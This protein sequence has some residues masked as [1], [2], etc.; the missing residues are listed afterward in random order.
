MEWRPP[1][2]PEP[3]KPKTPELGASLS[4]YAR[5]FRQPLNVE[6]GEDVDSYDVIMKNCRYVRRYRA[7]DP[8]VEATDVESTATWSRSP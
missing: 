1:P 2:P 5:A 3:E 8:H 4:A 6:D 7:D